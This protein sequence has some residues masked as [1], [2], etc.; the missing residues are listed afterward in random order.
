MKKVLIVSAV[1]ISLLV[2]A[3]W[4]LPAIFEDD[5]KLLVDEQLDGAVNAKIDFDHDRFDL[6]FFSHFPNLTMEIGG[7]NVM[8]RAPFEGDTLAYIDRLEV[9]LN[10]FSLFGANPEVSGVYAD[11]P[12][13]LIKTLEDGTANYDI[14]LPDTTAVEE[15]P[16]NSSDLTVSVQYWEVTNGYLAYEDYSLNTFFY[17]E[18][19]QHSGSGDFTLSVFDMVTQTE[20]EA[21]TLAYEGITYLD[22]ARVLGDITMNMDLTDIYKFTFLDNELKVNDFTVSADG[23]FSMPEDRYDM[24]INF[25]TKE[26]AFKNLLSLVPGV[27]LEGFESI[28]TDGSLQFEGFVK[29]SYSEE[30]MPGFK[31]DLLVNEA[32]F[33][34]PDLPTAVQNINVDMT[35]DNE[36]GNLDNLLID[37]RQFAMDLGQNPISGKLRLQGL[38]D[39]QIKADVS[40]KLNLAELTSM[41]PMEGMALEG[42][43]TAD[44]KADGTYSEAQKTMPKVVAILQLADGSVQSAEYPVPLEQIMFKAGIQNQT[45]L[46]NDTEIEV[47]QASMLVGDEPFKASGRIDQLEDPAYQFD[48]T[49]TFD[50]ALVE[51]I[52]PLDEGMH[53]K[54]IINADVHT[55]GRM[56][57]IEQERY[58]ELQTS[59]SGSL[60][61]FAFSSKDFPQ[62]ATISKA[63][64]RF[65]PQNVTLA[66]YAGT[67]GESDL[68]LSGTI[69]NYLGYALQENEVL[70]GNFRMQSSYFNA[71][72]WIAEE[73]TATADTTAE[74]AYETIPIP[75]NLDLAFVADLAKVDYT[76][77]SMQDMQGEITVKDGIM[78]LNGLKFNLLGGLFAMNGSYNT[79]DPEKP[80][81][82]FSLNIQK[83]SF[84]KSYQSFNTVQALAPIAQNINGDFT[85]DFSISGQIGQDFMP[86]YETLSG[87][88]LVKVND[89][90]LEGMA[91]L[92]KL[93]DLTSLS[94]LKNPKLKDLDIQA[95]IEDGKLKVQPFNF[96][97][98]G[99]QSTVS[100]YT[101][102]GG[103][104]AYDLSM[105]LPSEMLSQGLAAS[106][107]KYTGS[108]NIPLAFNIGGTYEKPEVSLATDPKA[109]AKEQL[110]ENAKEKIG[111]LVGGVLGD[112]TKQDS[113]Q[114]ANLDSLKEKAKDK[115]KEILPNNPFKKKNKDQ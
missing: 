44:V 94:Q 23:W 65:N 66:E 29:G 41:F 26:N 45:G 35:I 19:M 87:S 61:D 67:I 63:V 108:T 75:K 53:L 88:G 115:I 69:G 62:G 22:S 95:K 83:L 10:L 11:A 114:N 78:K 73:E 81:F 101:S 6:S 46:L 8:N 82:D 16:G 90:A 84:K 9:E 42:L 15:Q 103:A 106:L 36:Q 85:T 17:A 80:T 55:K 1:V 33:Q 86:I 52:Y 72:E 32:M 31:L 14:T 47:E 24:D 56:S 113:T 25:A 18:G 60:T 97:L 4:A 3:A 93:S 20:V 104:I 111:D 30:A 12:R 74:E 34:Y 70:T 54:G 2:V 89:A 100:G 105:Q 77:L 102:L 49:G 107:G 50:L 58:G 57:L 51:A 13:V 76:N 68:S 79:F 37:I 43:F 64:M 48:M 28:K 71:N 7:L 38:T 109:Q 112:T 99:V 92:N 21:F 98:A 27:F 110:K 59:G 39:Y 91:V 96:E 40:A 5:L